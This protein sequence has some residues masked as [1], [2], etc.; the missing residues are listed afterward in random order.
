MNLQNADVAVF[1]RECSSS[2]QQ[3]G[4]VGPHYS[5]S[6]SFF[7]PFANSKGE[8]GEIGFR[9]NLV[10][11]QCQEQMGQFVGLLVCCLFVTS[12]CVVLEKSLLDFT[13]F[14]I[15]WRGERAKL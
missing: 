14:S 12:C 7:F 11:T 4:F 2:V 10:N 1:S 15:L 6:S 3:Q 9:Y 8:R 5:S 13:M